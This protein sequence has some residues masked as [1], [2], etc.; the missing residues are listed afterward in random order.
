MRCPRVGATLEDDHHRFAVHFAYRQLPG[1]RQP[2]VIAKVRRVH[3]VPRK[4][5]G[6]AEP[7]GALF[8]LSTIRAAAPALALDLRGRHQ[9]DHL[10]GNLLDMSRITS[11]S[12][13]ALIKPLRWY[14]VIPEALH[15]VPAGKVRVDLPANMP[16]VDMN[17]MLLCN[18][19]GVIKATMTPAMTVQIP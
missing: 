12:V 17:C 15:G 5:L 13:N 1:P 2:L 18:W 8:A 7:G 6:N 4:P 3:K 10:V 11:D 9:L 16:A 19:G 14:E